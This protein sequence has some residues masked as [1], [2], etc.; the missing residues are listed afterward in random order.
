MSLSLLDEVC[1]PLY[2]HKDD[3]VVF[4]KPEGQSIQDL[5]LRMQELSGMKLHPVHRLDKD[6]S[7]LW[8]VAL[9]ANSNRELS[10]MFE[11]REV[12]KRYLALIHSSKKIKK[13][14]GLIVGDMEK[15]R[16]KSWRLL[17]SCNN[18]AET[19][20]Y[21]LPYPLEDSTNKIRLALL[22]PFTGK[23]H[24]LRV[25]MKSNGSAIIGDEIYSSAAEIN[26]SIER[27]YLHAFALAFDYQ[28][29][30][31]GF[32]SLPKSGEM[33]LRDDFNHCLSKLY[34]K[35]DIS[36]LTGHAL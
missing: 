15:S 21:T 8:L 30:S 9:N 35:Y 3:W 14:Q 6:T 27:L 26:P 22:L 18:P 28:G 13:K 5:L 11:R 12:T 7:G 29:E 36:P 2:Q 4:D 1:K 31:F 32:E 16:R 19:R 10:S 17:K 33:F 25:A 23:T 24:Q 34:S 20:F